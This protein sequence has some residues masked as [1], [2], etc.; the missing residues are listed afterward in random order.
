MTRVAAVQARVED[1]DVNANLAHLRERCAGLPDDVSVALFPEHF[2][3]GYAADA[4]IEDAALDADGRE[5]GAVR[6]VATAEGQDLLVG[7][8]ER[9]GE[10]LYNA[11]AYVTDTGTTVYRKRHLWGSERALLTP[12]EKRVVV[13][14]PVGR[15]GLL[16]CYDLN[17]VGESAAFTE[18]R[19]DALF[20]VGAWPAAHGSNWRLLARARA[21]DGV[22][23]VVAVGRTGKRT[24]GDERVAYNGRSLV[25]NPNGRVAHALDRRPRDLVATLD[26]ALLAEDRRAVGIFLEA[27][28]SNANR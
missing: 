15:T 5:L 27:S 3:T 12:G 22:R 28:E 24:V 21:L 26:P 18:E 6:E 20:V 11:A 9:D 14:T 10:T 23:W 7:F 19:V 4:R 2:L 17:F 8:V 1:L 16:T 13:E 25:V